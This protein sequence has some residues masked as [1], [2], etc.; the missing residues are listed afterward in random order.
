MNLLAAKTSQLLVVD[1]QAQLLPA[2][3]DAQGVA[4]N[5]RLLLAAAR[6]LGVP[7]TVSEQYVKGL[8]GTDPAIA[9]VLP[10]DS[11][12]LEKI[13]FSC[14]RDEPLRQRLQGL[15]VMGR[16]DLVVCG[17]EAHVCVL[18]TVLDA[19]AAGL[20]VALCADAVS[21]RQ[22]RNTDLA[23]ARAQRAGVDIVTTE[24]VVFEWLERAGTDNFRALLSQ[25]K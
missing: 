13:S 20:R 4:G 6:R 15:A 17:A 7:V 25:I 14:W 22:T 23:L 21:S 18:Q 11:V 19:R 9:D 8:G 24:M 12:K 2:V 16:G 3:I 5:I 10:A 1:A